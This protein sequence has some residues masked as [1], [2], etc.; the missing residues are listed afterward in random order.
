MKVDAAKAGER[1]DR[2]GQDLPIR[3]NNG[4]IRCQRSQPLNPAGLSK[5]RRLENA[6]S[7]SLCE[8]LDGRGGEALPAPCGPIRLRDDPDHRVASKAGTEARQ[9]KIRASKKEDAHASQAQR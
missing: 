3:D 2:F 1:E 5:S 9:R 6:D 8:P 4:E 7:G